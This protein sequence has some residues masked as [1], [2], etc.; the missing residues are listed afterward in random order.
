[1]DVGPVRALPSTCV[2]KAEEQP[3]DADNQRNVTRMGNQPSEPSA[4]VHGPPGE[5]T[6]VPSEYLLSSRAGPPSKPPWRP[7][8]SAPAAAW[9]QSCLCV[10]PA[11][12]GR[13]WP[14]QSLDTLCP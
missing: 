3:E 12:E 13:C 1:M 7:S 8:L 2:Q 14:H 9:G 5:A 10:A 6:A 4:A 11:G